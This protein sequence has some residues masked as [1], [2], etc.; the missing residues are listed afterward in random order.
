M[1]TVDAGAVIRRVLLVALGATVAAAVALATF[2]YP[3]PAPS[4]PSAGP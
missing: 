1:K 2:S 3:G 4:T